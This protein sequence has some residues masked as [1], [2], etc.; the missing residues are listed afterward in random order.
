MPKGLNN[1][2]LHACLPADEDSERAA[3][4]IHITSCKFTGDKVYPNEVVTL[5]I[6]A[7][8]YPAQI[9]KEIDFLVVDC[10]ST[11]NWTTNFES[12]K[13]SH[14]NILLEGEVT[15]G[16]WSGENTRRTSSC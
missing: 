8:T 2:P 7:R 4:S 13:S 9:S 12:S 6:I 16:L 5:T 10:L 1:H 3:P 14:S 11:D 15:N